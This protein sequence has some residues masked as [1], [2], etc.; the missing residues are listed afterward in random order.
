MITPTVEVFFDDVTPTDISCYAHSWDLRRGRAR[1]FDEITAGVGKV[2][3]RNHSG[4]FVP[5]DVV[6][7]GSA[8][9]DETGE[10]LLDEAGELLLDESASV[11]A[12]NIRPGKRM[13]V[14]VLG[15]V[16]FD[17]SIDDWNYWYDPSGRADAEI[18]AVD[19]LAD[20]AARRLSAHTATSEQRA[21][22]RLTALFARPEINYTGAVDFDRGVDR[23]QGNAIAE[24]ESLLTEAQLIARTDRGYFFASR[25]NTV[26]YRDRR[27]AAV[28]ESSIE[29]SDDCS[30]TP[31]TMIGPEFGRESWH[32]RVTVQRLGGT[33]QVADR[34][35]GTNIRTLALSGL[36]LLSDFY[37]AN[38]AEFLA[39]TYSEPRT[40]IRSL[41]VNLDGISTAQAEAVVALELGDVVTVTWTPEGISGEVT[42]ELVVEGI[43]HSKSNSTGY[44]VELQLSQRVQSGVFTL[45]SATLGVL[46]QSALAY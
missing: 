22:E 33:V 32:P 7:G 24:G 13:R 35:G 19:A 25:T 9:L 14:T 45:D 18:E 41:I 1:E 43:R 39:D 44:L 36:L 15:F 29:F 38:L 37:S 16:V 6:A 42:Q 3:L 23:L 40:R 10:E 34:S 27:A 30:E 21:G 8:L 5:Y 2:G 17:S 28:V 11:F 20:L 4:T 31:L 46:D 26:T 12:T